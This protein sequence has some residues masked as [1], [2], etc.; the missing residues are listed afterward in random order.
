MAGQSPVCSPAE[1]LS[2]IAKT[3]PTAENTMSAIVAPY[4]NFFVK[5]ASFILPFSVVSIP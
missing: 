3:M 5:V 2:V 1:D 4:F